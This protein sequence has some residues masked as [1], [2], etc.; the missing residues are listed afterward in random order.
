MQTKTLTKES[1]GVVNGYMHFHFG[2]AV[3]SVPY[4]N[5]KTHGTRGA[6]RAL[7]GKGTPD[8]IRDETMAVALK[9]HIQKDSLADEALKKILVESNLG[10]ECSGFAYH[11][12]DA[13]LKARLGNSR[14]ISH[15]IS[16]ANCD[17]V[18]ARIRCAMR[19]AENCNVRTFANDVN[20]IP[21]S[22]SDVKPGD[23]ITILATDDQNSSLPQPDRDHIL[24]VHA[25]DYIDGVPSTIHYSHSIAYPEDGLYGTG[26]RQGSIM[27]D[28]KVPDDSPHSITDFIWTENGR[29]SSDNLL[30]LRAKKSK[31]ELRRLTKN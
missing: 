20:S 15:S 11:V 27:L 4:F 9:M 14:G 12:L 3:A 31:T 10:I 13:E 18:L 30:F 21:V 22:Y 2:S 1:L 7:V 25:V 17:G 29:S 8:E 24:V 16:F 23:F 6:L 19:P 26:V 28:Q 5:N